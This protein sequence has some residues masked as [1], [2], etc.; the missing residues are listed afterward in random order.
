[1]ASI[2]IAFSRAL[3]AEA[4]TAVKQFAPKTKLRDA[5]VWYDGRDH[6][7]F[8]GPNNFYWHGRAGNAY[9]AR[10]HGWIAWLAQP[11]AAD[12]A[13][14]TSTAATAMRMIGWRSVGKSISMVPNGCRQRA[15]ASMRRGQR[16]G[17][18]AG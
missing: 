11:N 12:V 18:R 17:A 15:N 5:W 3:L 4:H 6:W 8:H 7:E 13:C 16:R 14:V 1:M 9:E 2:D 10:Y